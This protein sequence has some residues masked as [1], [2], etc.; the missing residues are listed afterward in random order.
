[1]GP[2]NAVTDGSA[3][4]IALFIYCGFRGND[5]FKQEI[6]IGPYSFRISH[7]M[8]YTLILTQMIAV[9]LK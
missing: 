4:I 5:L 2:G 8:G 9:I 6:P 3:A 7:I 1:M